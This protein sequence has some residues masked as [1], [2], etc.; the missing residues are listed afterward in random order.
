MVHFLLH[1]KY[2][3][4]KLL[5]FPFSSFFAF[6]ALAWSIL[7]VVLR[8]FFGPICLCLSFGLTLPL[9]TNIYSKWLTTHG[10]DPPHGTK[11]IPIVLIW[12]NKEGRRDR[13]RILAIIFTHK[14]KFPYKINN[15]S[16]KLQ[17]KNFRCVGRQK[18]NILWKSMRVESLLKTVTWYG[19]YGLPHF[20][21]V[22]I[23]MFV[24]GT[25]MMG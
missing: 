12:S 13:L 7:D 25:W 6:L 9:M 18:W 21:Y 5:C 19:D 16:M 4:K 2:W 22:V 14:I 8:K 17:N 20:R 24:L 11:V 1:Y 3:F 15:E 23:S 10:T